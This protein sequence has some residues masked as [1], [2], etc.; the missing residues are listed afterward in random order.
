ME[1]H[2]F[3]LIS[4]GWI[5]TWWNC[6]ADQA[7]GIVHGDGGGGNIWKMYPVIV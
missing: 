1:G 3:N 2:F 7:D 6:P 4:I 5:I